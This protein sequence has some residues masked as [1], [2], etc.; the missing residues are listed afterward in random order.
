MQI[1]ID[2]EGVKAAKDFARN[3]SWLIKKLQWIKR[4]GYYRPQ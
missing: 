2:E 3:P 4:D 1:K